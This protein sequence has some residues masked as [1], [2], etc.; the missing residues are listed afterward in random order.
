M[1]DPQ[2]ATRNPQ[3]A[4]RNPQPATRNPR[5]AT[6]TCAIRLGVAPFSFPRATAFRCEWAIHLGIAPF[7]FPRAARSAAFGMKCR[8]EPHNRET[9]NPDASRLGI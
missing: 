2:P 9:V 3:P 4:T 8:H 5:P 6:R 7:N 1:R